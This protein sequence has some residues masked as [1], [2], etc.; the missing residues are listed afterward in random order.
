MFDT[1]KFIQCIQNNNAIWDI[2]S[3]EY[4]NLNF[5]NNCWNVIAA[6]MY[7]NWI[8]FDQHKKDDLGKYRLKKLFM[9]SYFHS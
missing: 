1:D 2:E 3:K 8:E 9:L 7:S 6:M 5:K 4:K